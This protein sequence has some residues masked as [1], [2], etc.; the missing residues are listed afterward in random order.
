MKPH[1]PPPPPPPARRVRKLFL[2][3]AVVVAISM[4]VGCASLLNDTNP[5]V[6]ITSNP[7]NAD[8]YVD[9]QLMGRTPLTQNM[10]V[11]HQHAIVVRKEGYRDGARQIGTHT[12][13]LWVILDILLGLVPIIVD[14]ATG[15]WQE[16]NRDAVHVELEQE[17][18]G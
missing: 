2:S 15:D 8:V 6:S 7:T 1:Y 12:G 10:S 14:A 5:P 3:L 18:A 16:L 11:K 17:P 9:G 4:T 13:A